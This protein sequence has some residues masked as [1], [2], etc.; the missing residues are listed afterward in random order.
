VNDSRG[1]HREMF[2]LIGLRGVD[3]DEI[4]GT[5][6]LWVIFLDQMDKLH[7]GEHLVRGDRERGGGG[8]YRS[9]RAVAGKEID[10]VGSSVDPR[11]DLRY[12]I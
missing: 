4:V 1:R 3:D 11:H 12:L 2:S 9:I 8:W 6:V 5:E 10:C 7:L